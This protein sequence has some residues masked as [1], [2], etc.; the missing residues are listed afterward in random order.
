VPQSI[1]TA[2]LPLLENTDGRA[3]DAEGNFNP[4]GKAALAA[5]NMLDILVAT[6]RASI[7]L[8]RTAARERF[9]D[10]PRS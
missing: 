2:D 5:L 3:D 4:V 8:R 9:F 10:V 7:D 6:G 1:G